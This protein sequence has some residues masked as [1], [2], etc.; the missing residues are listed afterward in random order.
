VFYTSVDNKHL[1][2]LIF[3]K[4]K[5]LKLK[6]LLICTTEGPSFQSRV[7]REMCAGG[8][9]H[10]DFTVVTLLEE[11]EDLYAF[12]GGGGHGNCRS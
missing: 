3:E 8:A 7:I 4:P 5:S 12:F 6:V 11:S 2:S 9:Q 1:H 10:R